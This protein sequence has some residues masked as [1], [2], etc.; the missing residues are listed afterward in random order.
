M[1]RRCIKLFKELATLFKKEAE[2]LE[3]QEEEE[4][5]TD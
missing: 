1:A 2:V 3:E 5:E 4:E